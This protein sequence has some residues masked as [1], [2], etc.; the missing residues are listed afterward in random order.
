MTSQRGFSLVELVVVIAIMATLLAIATLNWREMNLKSGIENQIKK[1][2]ADLMEVRLQALYTKTPR[3]VVITDYQL[4]IYATD[5]TSVSVAPISV[6]D[7]PYKITWNN[8]TL[9]TFDAQGLTNGT[10]GSLCIVPTG[11]TS[12][13]NSAVVDSIVV[14]QARLNLGKR[15]GGACSAGNITQQ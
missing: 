1:I 7:L 3:S 6:K 14:S 10:Q 2:H 9:L 11:D 15:T 12:V 4:K 8:G 13:V 5:D